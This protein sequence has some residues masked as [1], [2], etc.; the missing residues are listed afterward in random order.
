M[1]VYVN[2]KRAMLLVEKFIFIINNCKKLIKVLD[3]LSGTEKITYQ[4]I[5]PIRTISALSY[6]QQ[7][8]I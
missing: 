2:E 5:N 7:R 6:F 8:S 3:S 1:E 4:D